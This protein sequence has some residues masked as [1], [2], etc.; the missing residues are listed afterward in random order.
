MTIVEILEE[1]PRLL[2]A[3]RREISRKLIEL[4]AGVDDIAMCDEAARVGF[5]LL[6]QMESEDSARA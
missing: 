1:L 4:E 6:E 5:T 2:P 3:E